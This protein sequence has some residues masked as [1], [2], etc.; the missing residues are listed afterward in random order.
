M[1]WK[2]KDSVMLALFLGAAN[3]FS[4]MI[5]LSYILIKK[6][7]LIQRDTW[8]WFESVLTLIMFLFQLFVIYKLLPRERKY[9]EAELV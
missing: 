2:N 7:A 4:W 8:V 3:T 1:D 6:E 5:I 9:F